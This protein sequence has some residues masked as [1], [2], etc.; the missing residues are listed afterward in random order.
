MS[1]SLEEGLDGETGHP[2]PDEYYQKQYRRLER[3]DNLHTQEAENIFMRLLKEIYID[4]K[5]TTVPDVADISVPLT[6]TEVREAVENRGSIDL[7]LAV[8]SNFGNRPDGTFF[9][10]VH[11][12]VIPIDD[13]RKGGNNSLKERDIRSFMLTLGSDISKELMGLMNQKKDEI[14]ERETE[15][16]I[17]KVVEMSEGLAMDQSPELARATREIFIDYR[18][19]KYLFD[20]ARRR[21]AELPVNPF[22][23]PDE[24]K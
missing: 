4:D 12:T 13:S 19:A 5:W 9:V 22:A 3:E 23:K 20:L 1:H 8:S 15:K 21:R 10:V 7:Q 6:C 14:D 18:F 2:Y 17:R 24:G 11:E 16:R